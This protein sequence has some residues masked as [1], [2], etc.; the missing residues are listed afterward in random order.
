MSAINVKN[1]AAADNSNFQ[2]NKNFVRLD[3]RESS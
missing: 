2:N 1:I 3:I